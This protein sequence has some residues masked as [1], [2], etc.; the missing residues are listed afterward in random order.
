MAAGPKDPLV[1][2]A[3]VGFVV[4]YEGVLARLA[5]QSLRPVDG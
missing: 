3:A 1:M 5:G 2:A 4:S